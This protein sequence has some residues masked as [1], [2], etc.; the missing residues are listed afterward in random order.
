MTL[1]ANETIVGFRRHADAERFLPDLRER[2]AT[3]GLAS[4][5]DKAR[6]IESAASRPSAGR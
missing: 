4:H 3:F 1:S 6:L 5:P 2:L